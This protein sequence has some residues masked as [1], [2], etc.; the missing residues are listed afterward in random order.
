MTT[1]DLPTSRA[2]AAVVEHQQ[3]AADAAEIGRWPAGFDVTY[4]DGSVEMFPDTG[5][6]FVAVGGDLTQPFNKV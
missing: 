3:D 4:G 1:H 6:T 2:G 5:F